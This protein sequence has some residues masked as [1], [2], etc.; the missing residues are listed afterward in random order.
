MPIESIAWVGSLQAFPLRVGRMLAHGLTVAVVTLLVL[1]A[2]ALLGL[3]N[4]L[5]NLNKGR[6]TR[7]TSPA[8]PRLFVPFAGGSAPDQAA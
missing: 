6:E 5:Q 8:G 2:F 7:P 3:V 1:F 4:V